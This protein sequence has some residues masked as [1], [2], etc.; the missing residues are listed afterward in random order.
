MTNGPH[1]QDIALYSV[2]VLL[3]YGSGMRELA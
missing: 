3:A 2:R 1:M